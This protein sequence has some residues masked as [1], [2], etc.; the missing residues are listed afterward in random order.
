MVLCMLCL[1][2]GIAV[3][4]NG[5][6]VNPEPNDWG[7]HVRCVYSQEDNPPSRRRIYPSG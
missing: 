4:I 6:G 3:R 2:C 7:E 5:S 1:F